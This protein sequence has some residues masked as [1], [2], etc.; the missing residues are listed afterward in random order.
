MLMGRIKTT[1]IKRT[2]EELLSNNPDKFTDH[3]DDNKKLLVGVVE[4]HSKKFRNVI[5]GYIT[6]LVKEKQKIK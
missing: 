1:L 6:R 2:G 4:L 3:F 5:A